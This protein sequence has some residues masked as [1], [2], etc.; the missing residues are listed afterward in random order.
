ML[1][2]NEK[3]ETME[4]GSSRYD[5]GQF[6]EHLNQFVSYVVQGESVLMFEK[7]ESMRQL[8]LAK[9]K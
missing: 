3:T 7:G 9:I 5:L 6:Y 1:A 2:A 8:Q 4:A